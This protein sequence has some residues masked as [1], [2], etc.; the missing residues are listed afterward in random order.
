MAKKDYY[1]ILGVDKNTSKD[2]IKKA[3][4]KLAI[5]YHPDKN[6]DDKQS[7]EKFKEVSEAYQV[8]SD[9]KKKSSYDMGGSFDFGDFDDMFGGGINFNDIFG[10]FGRRPQQ[11]PPR[12]GSSLRISVSVSL[13]EVLNGTKKEIKYKRKVKCKICDGTGSKNKE[14]DPCLRCSNTGQV[15]A[16]KR[17]ALGPMRVLIDCPECQ[18]VGKKSKKDC[19]ACNGTSIADEAVTEEI[20][21]PKGVYEGLEFAIIKRGNEAK[22][23]GGASGDLLIHIKEEPHQ[24]FKRNGGDLMCDCYISFAEAV[25]GA[26][27]TVPGIEENYKIAIE[28]GTPGGKILRLR[29]KGVPIYG[30]PSTGDLLIRINI[31]VPTELNKTSEKLIEKLKKE[32]SFTPQERFK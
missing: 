15:A 29:K 18:G 30:I 22:G 14:M 6:P 17:T 8:L 27:V 24:I 20:N 5:K 21:I 11:K 9:P 13:E 28:K 2:D 26:Q 19:P 16:E 7:E 10:G 3:Y 23:L 12:K 4:R 31:Y 1:K 32:E 25:D